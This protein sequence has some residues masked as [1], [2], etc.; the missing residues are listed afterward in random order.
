[1][2]ILTV[3]GK[4]EEGAY[5]PN[6]GANNVLYLFVDHEDAERNS[7]LLKADDYPDMKIIE[8][9]DEIAINICEEKMKD[10]V[11]YARVIHGQEELEKNYSVMDLSNPM[12]SKDEK[13]YLNK[14]VESKELH[15]HPDE[16]IAMYNED[17]LGGLIRNVEFWIKD[18]F[19]NLVIKK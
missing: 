10:H 9:E 6:V 15:Y 19:A 11:V 2:Y 1:M 17:Q 4:E 14:V 5:A 13:H 3:K 18:V 8:V 16:F 12:L 7:E